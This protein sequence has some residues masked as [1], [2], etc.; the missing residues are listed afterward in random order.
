MP[1]DFRHQALIELF[2]DSQIDIWESLGPDAVPGDT[3]I[4][5]HKN[6]QGIEKRLKEA[7]IDSDHCALGKVMMDLF[8]VYQSS[9]IE[10]QIQ[11]LKESHKQELD[12]LNGA[13]YVT[14]RQT[15]MSESGMSD[16]DFF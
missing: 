15:Q 11:E 2:S 12:D 13:S 3:E 7:I 14:P 6:I 16:G 1:E 9:S 4:E 5:F 8:T 10:A